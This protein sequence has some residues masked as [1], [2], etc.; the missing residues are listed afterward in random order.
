MTQINHENLIKDGFVQID[1]HL[2]AKENIYITHSGVA[3]QLCD[4]NS[5]VGNEYVETMEQIYI[6]I[7]R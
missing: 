6:A 1:K 5:Y 4:E 3:W 7:N 2:Y